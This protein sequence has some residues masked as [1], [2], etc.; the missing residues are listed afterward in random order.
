MGF[1]ILTSGS[2]DCNIETNKMIIQ[3]SIKYIKDTHRFD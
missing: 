3:T 1:P 2:P